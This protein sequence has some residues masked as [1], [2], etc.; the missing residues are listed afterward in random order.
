[1]CIRDSWLTAL[2][3]EKG[4]P[5]DLPVIVKGQGP[6]EDWSDLAARARASSE[7]H[8]IKMAYSCRWLDEAFGPEPLYKLAVLDMLKE[9]KAQPQRSAG[10]TS[11]GAAT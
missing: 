8:L 7:V 4:Q 9:R 6:R 10:T 5:V 1:M 3:I 11:T 2:Y